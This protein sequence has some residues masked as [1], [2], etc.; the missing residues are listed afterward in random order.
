MRNRLSG[1]VAHVG[2]AKR[3][4]FQLSVA[5]IDHKVMFFAQIAHQFG[6]VDFFSIVFHTGEGESAVTLGGEKLEA[7]LAHPLVDERV[8]TRV[9]FVAIR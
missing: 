4:A 7:A 5:S 1:F 6:H 3:L 2:E 8:S 9:P